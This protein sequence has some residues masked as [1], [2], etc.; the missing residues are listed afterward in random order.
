MEDKEFS[1]IN[2]IPFVDILLVLL[3]IVLITASFMVQGVIPVNLPKVKE[4]KEEALK[5]L[6]IVLTKEGEI[7]FEGKRVSLQELE[8]ILKSLSPSTKISLSADR[9][10]KVQSLVSLLDLFKRYGLERVVIRTE[11]KSSY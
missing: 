8:H 2:V 3:T 9:E 6:E 1:S 11:I 7:Y 5:S 4:G 10:A